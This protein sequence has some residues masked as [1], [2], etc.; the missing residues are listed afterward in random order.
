MFIINSCDRNKNCNIDNRFTVVLPYYKNLYYS[1]YNAV[2]PY[3]I[4]LISSI[5]NK[6]HFVKLEKDAIKKD[7]QMCL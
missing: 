6:F 5:K 3:N 2:K 7:T 4:K 1:I